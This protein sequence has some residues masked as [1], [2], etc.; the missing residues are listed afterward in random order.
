MKKIKLL[1]LISINLLS[2]LCIAQ[3]EFDD[4]LIINQVNALYPGF[5]VQAY[6]GIGGHSYF[7]MGNFGGT[8][9][10]PLPTPENVILGTIIYSGYDGQSDVQIGRI[11]VTSSGTFSTGN[12]P[13]KMNFKLGGNGTC[14]GINRMTIDGQ[15][16]NVGIGIT[17]PNAKLEVVDEIR[18]RLATTSIDK[19]VARIV[20]LGYSGITGA[21]NW[22]IRGTYQYW[23][24]ISH[25]SIGG[26][27]DLIK[28]WNGNTVLATKTDGSTLGNVGIGTTSPDAPLTVKGLI[29]SR[30][31]KVTATA[32]GADFVFENE[33]DLPTLEEVESYIKKN[34]HL[35]EIA[36]AK[37]MEEDGIHL[38]EMNIKLLQKIEELTLYTI[39][40]QKEINEQAKEV[41]KLKSI[42]E[43]LLELQSRLEKLES[44]K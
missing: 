26:D 15:S 30:E 2:I 20:P 8:K 5:S 43:K 36:S 28:S 32:G 7:S 27:L 10:N 29:H 3:T 39:N 1:L 23:N 4:K 42:N 31:V 25:N 33:Y 9:A 21:M 24:G 13:A 11:D 22:S 18:L 35:P 17:D 14:C 38:A 44:E 19:N 16:G 34:K 37:D 41:K 6:Q 40:Q 12:Y